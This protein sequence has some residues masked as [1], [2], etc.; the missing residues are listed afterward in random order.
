M[1]G[2]MFGRAEA[3]KSGAESRPA[4]AAGVPREV[5]GPLVVDLKGC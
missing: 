5:A 1:C 2:W 3:D 4:P